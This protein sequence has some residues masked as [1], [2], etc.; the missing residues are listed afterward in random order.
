MVW[1]FAA[2]W[3][4]G[5]IACSTALWSIFLFT[6][7]HVITRSS[8]QGY[9]VRTLW[10]SFYPVLSK[11][12]E[13][14]IRRFVPQNNVIGTPFLKCQTFRFSAFRFDFGS[15]FIASSRSYLPLPC[16]MKFSLLYLRKQNKNMENILP[17]LLNHHVFYCSKT[18]PVVSF[19]TFS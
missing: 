6:T 14:Q 13:T 3:H 10:T 7:G 2:E 4:C 1:C 11:K 5:Y 8:T 19:L 9:D 17:Y 15:K 16:A 12:H 18:I